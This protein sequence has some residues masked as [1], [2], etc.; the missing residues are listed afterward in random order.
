M[1]INL[2]RDDGAI[3]YL[4]GTEIV[5]SNMPAGEV[6]Y[7]TFAPNA[8]DDGQSLHTYTVSGDALVN[9]NNVLAVEVH[10]VNATSS[11]LSFDLSLETID[12]ANDIASLGS[13]WSYLDDG[14]DQGTAWREPDFDDSAWESGPAQ[15]GFGEG[16]EATVITRGATTFYFRHDFNVDSAGIVGLEINLRRDDGA[17]IYLNGTEIVRSN[18]LARR[19]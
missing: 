12:T 19:C 1:E 16:D 8:S 7:Q 15:L 13:T 14:T 18:M 6:D 9:G 4:N 17:I 3:I 5:R 2:R 10:Q 11:D